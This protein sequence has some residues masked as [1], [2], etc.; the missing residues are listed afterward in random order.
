MLGQAALR[1]EL[2]VADVE[3]MLTAQVPSD[4]IVLK[5]EQAQRHIQSEHEGHLVL[6]NVGASADLLKFMISGETGSAAEAQEI[7]IPD[8]TE[9]KLLLK[10]ALSSATAQPELRIEFMASEAIVA[11]GVTVI[12]KAPLQ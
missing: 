1:Q 4:V 7:T 11:H 6:K 8:G 12:E 2:S 10:N 5:L 9:V 3:T